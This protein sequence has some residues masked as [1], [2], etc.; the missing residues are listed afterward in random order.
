MREPQHPKGFVPVG[1]IVATFGL[2]GDV[3]VNPATNIESRFKKGAVLVMNGQPTKILTSR[4]Q[5]KQ[6]V[7]TLEG[8]DG[9]AAAEKLQWTYLYVAEDE[10]PELEQDEYMV[11]DLVGMKVV[12]TDGQELGVVD[13]V[14]NYP[15]HDLLV[16]GDLLIPAVAE[17]VEMVDFDAETI[18]VRL[19]EGMLDG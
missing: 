4:L 9:I 19:I 2:K 15:A 12:T 18:T 7:L 10:R 14:L 13:D 17:F 16:I 3:K 8:V 11:D 1:Q 5:K 6:Y